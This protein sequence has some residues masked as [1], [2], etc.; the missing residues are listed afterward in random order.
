M[1]DLEAPAAPDLLKGHG[2]ERKQSGFG[3]V[4]QDKHFLEFR[5]RGKCKDSSGSSQGAF[6][7]RKTTCAWMSAEMAQGDSTRLKVASIKL[8]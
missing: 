6:W 2:D 3:I 8:L 1:S 5:R 4:T 7:T